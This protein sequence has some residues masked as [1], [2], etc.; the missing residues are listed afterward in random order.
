MSMALKISC[1]D[2]G[3]NPTRGRHPGAICSNANR[4]RIHIE[5]LKEWILS[6]D[7]S[8]RK[9]SLQDDVNLVNL[10]LEVRA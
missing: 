1:S 6:L 10:G 5:A 7:F 4:S 9:I 3:L 8:F 2:V